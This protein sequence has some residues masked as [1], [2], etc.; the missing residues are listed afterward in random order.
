MDF[1][2]TLWCG[3]AII[4]VG[5]WLIYVQSIPTIITFVTMTILSIMVHRAR[6]NEK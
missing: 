2:Y 6:K 4:V 3:T 1:L 5:T